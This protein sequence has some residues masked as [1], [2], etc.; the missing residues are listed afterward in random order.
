MSN[1]VVYVD[2]SAKGKNSRVIG[3]GIVC[4]DNDTHTELSGV[5]STDNTQLGHYHEEFAM[6]EAVMY[7]HRRGFQPENCSIYTDDQLAGNANFHLHPENYSGTGDI[8][9]ARYQKLCEVLYT[10]EVYD[11]VMKFLTHAR[12]TK[13]KG[14]SRIVYNL[15][16]DYVAQCATSN[17]PA[18]NFNEWLSSAEYYSFHESKP[19]PF[20][21]ERQNYAH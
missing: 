5:V 9:R 21:N 3:F 16:V 14:H 18:N 4:L 11:I 19:L 8:I 7:L 12:L 2:G 6:V 10:N 13:V 20:H 17:L 15:R 1:A